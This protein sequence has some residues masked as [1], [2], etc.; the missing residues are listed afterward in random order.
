MTQFSFN[1]LCKV[2]KW[3][4]ITS[5]RT[6][7]RETMGI[8]VAILIM[9]VITSQ[10]IWTREI[11][12]WNLFTV[13]AFVPIC[14]FFAILGSAGRICYNMREKNDIVNYLMVP[15]SKLEKFITNFLHQSVVRFASICAGIALADAAQMLFSLAL[16]GDS[17]SLC[18]MLID[19]NVFGFIA[20]GERILDNWLVILFFHSSFTLGGCFFR[21]NPVLMTFLTWCVA[22][23]VFS[24]IIG[25]GVV[26]I[27]SWYQDQPYAVDFENLDA[28]H[29]A[30]E[31]FVTVITLLLTCLFYWLAYNRFCHLQVINNK[32]FN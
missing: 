28:Y 16:A 19:A 27:L 20:P 11:H 5:R 9:T 7:V 3:D 29:Y 26:G 15:A 2:L 22:G 17:F 10:V 12:E 8:F 23:L 4:L 6:L 1:R 18:K 24:I 25:Y 14:V 21:K 31:T 13:K 30:L 32:Y